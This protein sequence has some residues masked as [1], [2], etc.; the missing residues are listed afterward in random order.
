MIADLH[1]HTLASDGTDTPTQL[2][3]KAA[4]QGLDLIAITDHDTTSGWD[5]ASAAAQ[6]VG[7]S[8]LRGIEISCKW[9]EISLHLLAYLHERSDEPLL[10]ELSAARDSRDSRARRITELLAADLPITWKDVSAQVEPGATVGRPHIA[11]ALV[12][13]GIVKQRDEAFAK[14]L[15]TGSPYYAAHYAPDPVAVVKLVRAA[16]GVPVMAHPFA[17]ARGPVA[18]DQLIAEMAQAGL[19]ALEADH[20]EHDDSQRAHT[21]AL[22]ADLGLHVTGSSDYHGRGKT[23]RLGQCTTAPTVVE[24]LLSEPTAVTAI[25]ALGR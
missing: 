18:P 16:R 14:Y 12:A 4:A 7:I 11:D 15:Y 25:G 17:A 24:A 8:L 21:I 1:A 5:E 3:E 23:N 6:R 9:Q 20:P 13:L 2:I 22:A 19:F 10:A